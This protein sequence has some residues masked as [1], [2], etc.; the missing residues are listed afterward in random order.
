MHTSTLPS[1]STTLSVLPCSTCTSANEPMCLVS[2]IHPSTCLPTPFRFP[3]HVL[4]FT[5]QNQRSLASLLPHH[6]AT[7]ANTRLLYKFCSCTS[8]L[9]LATLRCSFSET[10]NIFPLLHLCLSAAMHRKRGGYCSHS[11]FDLGIRD[12]RSSNFLVFFFFCYFSK[13]LRPSEASYRV[14]VKEFS[15]SE[16]ELDYRITRL[17]YWSLYF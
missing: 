12:T 3:S 16:V 6:L 8:V 1:P 2:S 10:G 5:A 7:P 15:T 14:R 11:G 17:H 13:I 4:F 9:S